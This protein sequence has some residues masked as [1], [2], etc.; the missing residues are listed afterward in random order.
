MERTRQDRLILKLLNRALDAANEEK[1]LFLFNRMI[2]R[3]NKSNS[4]LSQD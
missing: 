1:I 4:R 2:E 3:Q